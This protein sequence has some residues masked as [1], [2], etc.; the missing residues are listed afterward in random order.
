MRST[1]RPTLGPP[2]CPEATQGN[3]G[4]VVDVAVLPFFQGH[5]GMCG[6]AV[7]RRSEALLEGH[8]GMQHVETIGKY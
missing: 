6:V 8:T 4:R 3:G 5:A 1:L 7:H 2:G